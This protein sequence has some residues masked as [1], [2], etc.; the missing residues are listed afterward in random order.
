LS[1]IEQLQNETEMRRSQR[2]VLR[3]PI[4]VRWTPPGESSITEESTTLVGECAR[5]VG[6]AGDEGESGHTNFRVRTRNAG[7]CESANGQK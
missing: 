1:I 4:Q 3:M 5:G 6:I 7:W 2:V